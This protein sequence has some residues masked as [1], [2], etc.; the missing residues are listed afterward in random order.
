MKMLLLKFQD[1]ER[2]KEI[3]DYLESMKNKGF[4]YIDIIRTAITLLKEKEDE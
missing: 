3:V 2:D 1:K 4:S